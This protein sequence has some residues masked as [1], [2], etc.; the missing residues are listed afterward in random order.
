M[1]SIRPGW[2]ILWQEVNMNI[3]IRCIPWIE[4]EEHLLNVESVSFSRMY[5]V[6]DSTD[7]A[8]TV[9]FNRKAKTI[10]QYNLYPY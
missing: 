1:C 9:G 4:V 6:N 3:I 7:N 5:I 10:Y 8:L 2:R